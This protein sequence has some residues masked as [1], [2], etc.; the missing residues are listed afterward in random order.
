MKKILLISALVFISQFAFS[1]TIPLD[2]VYKYKGKTVTV[3][4]KVVD[5]YMSK[6]KK[7][8]TYL[9]FGKPFP[10]QTFQVVIFKKDLGN[11]SYNPF[12]FLE[13]KNV[14]VTGEVIF[15]KGKPEIIATKE[16]QIKVE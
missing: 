9:N 2:S 1:Q 3:C 16:A 11:F 10:Y 13:Q 15:F 14:C 12:E 7:G 6:D 8:G 5:I 4:S